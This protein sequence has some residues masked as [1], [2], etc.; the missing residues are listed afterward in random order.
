MPAGFIVS[1]LFHLLLL[2]GLALWVHSTLS[3]GSPEGQLIAWFDLPEQLESSSEAPPDPQFSPPHAEFT[4]PNLRLDIPQ[5]SGLDAATLHRAEPIRD[6]LGSTDGELPDLSRLSASIVG[7]G[8][9][10]RGR[11]ARGRLAKSEGGTA[12]SEKAVEWGLNWL[13]AHQMDDGSWRF[14]HNK[15]VCRGQCR[16][17]GTQPSTTAATAI[18]VMAFL[19]AGYSHTEGEHQETLKRA[20]YY[21]TR[22]ALTTSNGTDFRE[23]TMYAQGLATIALCEAYAMTGDTA[24]KSYAQG[25]IDFIVFAQD[26]NG[27]GWRYQPGEPGDTTVSGWM[28]M[29]L[30]SGQMAKLN[31]PSTTIHDFRRFLDSVQ[32]RYGALYGYKD[33]RGQRTTTAIGLLMRMY[34]G[35]RRHNSALRNGAA[36]ISEWGPSENNMYYNYYATQV[37][38]HRGGT[39]WEKWNRHMREYLIAT[40]ARQGHESGSWYFAERYGDVGGRLYNT[41]MAVMTLEVYYR[42]M[43]LY[44][45]KSVKDNF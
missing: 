18:A 41:A 12:Q 44:K 10:G 38:H 15:S 11:D 7:G 4:T 9:E 3:A 26:R 35:W 27:G 36:Y 16:N 17:A 2:L 24:L 34:T 28:V 6:N 21:L 40:Q 20:L 19:G 39:E 37:M 8:L 1:L 33:T 45:E 31:V 32:S 43:P 23:G 14:D 30:K 13:A 5:P 25:G 42:Y 22:Q 29:A